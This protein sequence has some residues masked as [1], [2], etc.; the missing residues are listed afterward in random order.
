MFLKATAF[1][2]QRSDQNAL[3]M[4]V[5]GIK[6]RVHSKISVLLLLRHLFDARYTREGRY[7]F[8]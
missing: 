3:N 7:R 6:V 4:H 8:R 5:Y 1:K 2:V